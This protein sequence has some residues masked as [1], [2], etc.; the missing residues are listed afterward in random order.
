MHLKNSKMVSVTEAPRTKRNMTWDKIGEGERG[1]CIQDSAKDFGIYSVTIDE[2]LK[3]FNEPNEKSV[4]YFKEKNVGFIRENVLREIQQLAL[5]F[6][7]FDVSW[8]Y[9]KY[10]K[11]QLAWQGWNAF[12]QLNW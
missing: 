6:V 7:G 9:V 4:L 10:I 8:S 5:G 1:Q 2:C 12:W 11:G 3:I